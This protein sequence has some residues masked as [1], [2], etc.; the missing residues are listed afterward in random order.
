MSVRAKLVL[1]KISQVSWNPEVRV[2][3]FGAQY[4]SSIPEDQRFAKATPTATAEFTVDN[5]AAV[6][7]FVLGE[8]YYVDFAP[9]PKT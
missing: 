9:A 2:L 6:A 5:P 8:A 1:Q 4:D 7:Q 3:T